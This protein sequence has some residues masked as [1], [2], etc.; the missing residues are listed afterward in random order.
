MKIQE[1]SYDWAWQPERRKQ[2]RDLILHHCGGSG[3]TA[4]AI[5]RLHRNNGWAGIGY[6][7]Y[8]RKD[9]TVVRGRPEDRVGT[10]TAYHNADSIGVCF[11]GNF[12]TDTMGT[13][14]FRAGADLLRDLRA[15]YPSAALHC[16]RD[17]N[18]TACPGTN[19]PFDQLKEES[20]MALTQEEFERMAAL[21]LEHLA[22]QP[23]SDW[24]APARAW[25]EQAGIIQGDGSGS[26]QY[27]RPLT[28]EEYITM[29]YRMQGGGAE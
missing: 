26:F 22:Q 1:E 8:I 6:H 29:A 13:A 25:A 15:R 23:P 4:Q 28:R 2:T 5:H 21:W 27:R 16:H 20:E 18:A 19:F 10:H 14:Q 17:Y 24:S 3:L 7:Y 12:E 11:E 9:G